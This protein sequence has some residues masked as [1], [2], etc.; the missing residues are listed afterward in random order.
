M[1]PR[2]AISAALLIF[3]T[4]VSGW[5]LTARQI[6]NRNKRLA[7]PYSSSGSVKLV[8]KNSG[9]KS[10]KKFRIYTKKFGSETRSRINFLYPNRMQ[11]LIH[12]L[13]GGSTRQW[14][15]LSS[16]R[17]RRV[18]SG[19]RAG[20]WAGSHFY[21]ED[22]RTYSTDN[23]NLTRLKD[24]VIRDYHK[25]RIPCYRILARSR[26]RGAVYS[27][28]ILFID[29]NT[30]QIRRVKFYQ[31]GRHTKTLSNYLFK[32]I[33]GINTPRLIYMEPAGRRGSYSYLLIRNMRFNLPLS[34]SLFRRSTF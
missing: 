28:Q 1:K 31:R 22:L 17:I 29:K 15:K 34:S 13:P 2:T 7:K 6:V 19:S 3:M 12:S 8:I 10:R 23:Y 25:K 16:G 33:N 11:F 21:Y 26:L 18:A 32:K 5:G 24:T 30:W 9:L 20:S 14:I 27:K 4:A